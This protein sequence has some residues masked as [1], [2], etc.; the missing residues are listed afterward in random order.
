MKTTYYTLGKVLPCG[1]RTILKAGA[2]LGVVPLRDGDDMRRDQQAVRII[3]ALEHA[4]QLAARF[5]AP[6]TGRLPILPAP[7][8]RVAVARPGLPTWRGPIEDVVSAWRRYGSETK[9]LNGYGGVAWLES[10]KEKAPDAG[11]VPTSDAR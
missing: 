9:H 6:R 2:T 11:L 4:A 7:L 5:D 10:Q 8:Y 1:S 3:S